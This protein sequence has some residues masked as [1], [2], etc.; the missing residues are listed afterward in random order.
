MWKECVL[1][2][3]LNFLEVNDFHY[4]ALLNEI[5]WDCFFLIVSN[6]FRKINTGQIFY[7]IETQNKYFLVL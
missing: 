6:K 1:K 3:I 4:S 5:H 7:D 2:T